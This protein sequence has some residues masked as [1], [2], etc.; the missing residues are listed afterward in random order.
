MTNVVTTRDLVAYISSYLQ[1]H[2]GPFGH[3]PSELRIEMHPHLEDR[4]LAEVREL[5][6]LP[7]PLINFTSVFGV[8]YKPNSELEI[9]GWRLVIV[10]ERVLTGGKLP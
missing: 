9:D 8:P 2:F 6:D 4:I 5:V 3:Y 1:E 10:T 7:G